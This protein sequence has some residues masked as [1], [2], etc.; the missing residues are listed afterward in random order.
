VLF[1]S[2][3]GETLGDHGLIQK[4]CRFYEGLVRVPMI[5]RWPGQVRQ[6]QSDAL[7][8]LTDIA[9]T[10]LEFCG[11][12]V[13]DHCQGRSLAPILRGQAAAD[14][15]RDFV[16]SEYYD[17]L[18]LPGHSRATMHRTD[19]HKLVTYHGLGLGELFD[20]Q[21]DPD[22]H[23]NLWDDPAHAATRAALMAESFDAMAQNFPHGSRRIG[24]Y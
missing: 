9:P 12:G 20:L 11:L 4:G 5:W 23:E 7:V 21:T 3:H 22:E 6:G 15:H 16:R 13:P 17:A 18:D 14:H 10:L 8:E 24:P 19:R 1:M 2:D